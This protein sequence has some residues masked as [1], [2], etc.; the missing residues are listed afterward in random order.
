LII[1]GSW[2]IFRYLSR[3]WRCYSWKPR[4]WSWIWG[5]YRVYSLAYRSLLVIK[6]I[7]S[8]KIWLLK[9]VPTKIS[10][11]Y[12]SYYNCE[13]TPYI[14]SNIKPVSYIS[15]VGENSHIQIMEQLVNQFKRVFIY[16][17]YVY[18]VMNIINFYFFYVS[19]IFPD[20][21]INNLKWHLSVKKLNRMILMN[22]FF[23]LTI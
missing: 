21:F 14:H 9:F 6:K 5:I 19:L 16:F 10:G 15:S 11:F 7:L 18:S 23:F 4:N 1:S 13:Y 2:C 22:S 12:I 8:H 17:S 3:I 20:I